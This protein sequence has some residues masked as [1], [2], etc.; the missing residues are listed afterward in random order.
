[1]HI[2]CDEAV[3]LAISRPRQEPLSLRVRGGWDERQATKDLFRFLMEHAH[4]WRNVDFYDAGENSISQLSTVGETPLLESIFCAGD[5]VQAIFES[6]SDIPQLRDVAYRFGSGTDALESMGVFPW[7]SIHC[8]DMAYNHKD[9]PASVFES[10]RH[11]TAIRSL[12]F[13][14]DALVSGETPYLHH[15]EPLNPVVSNLTTLSIRVRNEKGFY[16]LLHDFFSSLTLPSLTNLDIRFDETDS[17][18]Q[19]NDFGFCGEWPRDAL[20]RCIRRSS[21]NLTTLALEGIPIQEG[22]LVTLL[23]LTP[24]LRAFTLCEMWAS[25]GPHHTDTPPAKPCKTA[26]SQ[27]ITRSFLKRLEAPTLSSDPFSVQY[28]LLPKLTYLKLVVQAHFDA[29]HI[30]VD[31]VKS[32]CDRS[33]GDL[34]GYPT[35]RLRTAVLHVVNKKLVE[36]RYEPLKRLDEEGMMI[37]V[38]GDGVR[39][40]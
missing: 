29:D 24:S 25:I 19:S 1:M 22:D 31:M 37:T 35:E 17:N 26:L 33:N 27:T 4:R 12:T 2:R 16:A 23:N 32:R 7:T 21:Y 14:G 30:F 13:E 38:S 10:L 34:F 18:K 28:P 20:H 36:A 6:L 5:D 9:T 3:R 11:G 39:V 8:L 15:D 40:V